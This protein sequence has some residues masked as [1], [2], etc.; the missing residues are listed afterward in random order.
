M[1]PVAKVDTAAADNQPSTPPAARAPSRSMQLPLF[2]TAFDY[3]KEIRA[4]HREQVANPAP[5]GL[6]A[7]G[8]TTALLQGANTAITENTT[9]YLTWGFAM[10]FGGLAQLL[11][12]MWEFKR[13]NTFGATAFTSYGAFW[14][15]LS[16]WGILVAARVF[17]PTVHGFQMM[18]A[19]W[20]IYTFILMVP[21]LE[22]NFA[23]TSLFFT[24][25]V[26]FFMLA[27]GVVTPVWSKIGGWWGLVV[28]GIAFYIAAADIINEEFG[29]T[30]LPLGKWGVG[31]PMARAMR[32]LFR[33]IPG[34]NVCVWGADREDRISGY[35]A[36]GKK[37]AAKKADGKEVDPEAAPHYVDVY[38]EDRQRGH[39]HLYGVDSI[40]PSAYEGAA[41][42]RQA[43]N[44]DV[45]S[46]VGPF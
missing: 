40:Q 18:L 27:G 6:F 21:T 12:G 31:R 8:L 38:G 9:N 26:L 20:G 34:P 23:L 35:I 44:A 29:M 11:A 5:L 19:L 1:N 37:G 16:L 24:L 10:F 42:Q 39:P 25:S 43:A 32:E 22:L 15:S 14:M 45:R 46:A 7:F 33:R 4:V 3:T 41:V 36:Q 28:A 13:Q 2:Q 30:V 17:E